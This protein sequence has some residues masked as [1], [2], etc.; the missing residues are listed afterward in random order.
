MAKASAKQIICDVG[1]AAKVKEKLRELLTSEIVVVEEMAHDGLPTERSIDDQ[2]STIKKKKSF[3]TGLIYLL[4]QLPVQ[5]A[6]GWKYNATTHQVSAP[7]VAQE[8]LLPR[9]KVKL[10]FE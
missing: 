8:L 10:T 6:N 5:S 9:Q 4:F 1:H 7:R 3:R 2:G